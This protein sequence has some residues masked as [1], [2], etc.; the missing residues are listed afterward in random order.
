MNDYAQSLDANG[1]DALVRMRNAA[2]RMDAL[3]NGLLGLARFSYQDFP[4]TSLD[5]ADVL[6]TVL[7]SLEQDIAATAATVD[8]D[9]PPQHVVAHPFLATIA[10]TQF[11]SNGLK[12]VP[13][14]VAPQLR[15][16]TQLRGD[17]VRVSVTDNGIGIPPEYHARIFGMFQ[18]LHTNDAYPG[19]GVGLT[20]A[21][22]AAERMGGSVGLRSEPGG[23]ST[24]WIEFASAPTPKLLEA[25]RA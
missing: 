14:G 13:P 23:G 17:R 25:Q 15:V 7:V 22:R 6:Q 11:I 3:I 20:L 2:V 1:R 10:L 9:V 19:V 4:L 18:R 8:V 5:I 24:F 12:F 21:Q 16:R